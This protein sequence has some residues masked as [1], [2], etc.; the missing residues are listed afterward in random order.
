[1]ESEMNRPSPD[2]MQGR[3]EKLTRDITGVVN[4]AGEV[5]K[6]YGSRKFDSARATLTQ[7]QAAVGDSYKQAVDVT[8]QYVHTNPWTAVGVAAAAG[9]LI[10]LLL[11]RR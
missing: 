3:H 10:G 9:V 2:A 1:M 4:E 6:D 11:G 5:L 8:D 7:A